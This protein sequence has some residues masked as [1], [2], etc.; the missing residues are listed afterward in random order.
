[1]SRAAG[2]LANY[3]QFP[4]VH[5]GVALGGLIPILCCPELVHS[6]S[7][8]S[9]CVGQG[10]MRVKPSEKGVYYTRLLQFLSL[11]CLSYIHT[12]YGIKIT[13][14]I[15]TTCTCMCMYMYIHTL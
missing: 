6:L 3:Q 14:D 11:K 12:M 8:V 10:Y 7:F 9:V 1:M 13:E 15:H 4:Y 5:V 2:L